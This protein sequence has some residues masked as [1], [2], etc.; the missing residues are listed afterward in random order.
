[1]AVTVVLQGAD[2]DRCSVRVSPLAELCACLHAFNAPNHHPDSRAW[3]GAVRAEITPTLLAEC[4][5]WAP[6]WGSR[7]AQFM[8]PSDASGECG[9][10]EEMSAIERLPAGEFVAMAALPIVDSDWSIDFDRLLTDRTARRTFTE[11]ARRLSP[12]RLQLAELL[13]GDPAE[14][15]RQLLTFLRRF[16]GRVFEPEWHRVLPMLCEEADRRRRELRRDGL[17]VIARVTST[18]KEEHHPHRVVFDKLYPAQ[19]RLTD[20]P[21]V[22]LPSAHA[23]PHVTIKHARGFPI[24]IQYAVKPTQATPFEAVDRRVKAL[25][26]PSRVRI[27]RA[28][29]RGRHTTVDLAHYIGMTEPQV[30]RHLR[31][32]R[33]A[34]LVRASR[35]G[36]MVFYELDAEALKRIGQ[37][38][39]AAL[40]R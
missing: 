18:A 34:G 21:C 37:D 20:A 27:C 33:E 23:G 4:R 28:I 36:R 8:F 14:F 25:S 3:A 15:H 13:L 30:S 5:A 12:E 6:L 24:A 19:A 29:L 10:D 9:L 40:W 35:E 31:R 22:L 2:A 7:R 16:C 11:H 32:L 26:D 1:V 17:A 38:F 39:Y